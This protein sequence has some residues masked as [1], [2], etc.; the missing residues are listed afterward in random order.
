LSQNTENTILE[1]WQ[2]PQTIER[3]LGEDR[4][5]ALRRGSVDLDFHLRNFYRHKDV[6]VHFFD[7]FDE[8]IAVCQ[9]Y[10]INVIVVASGGRLVSEIELLRSIK[11]NVFLSI[12]PVVLYHPNP[13]QA[14]VIAAYENGVEDF[15]YGDWS[16]RLVEVRINRAIERNHRDLSINPSTYLPGP[17]MIDREIT[18]LIKA[19]SEFAV[20]YADLDNF[21]AFN[22]YYGYF[23][24]DK[25]IRLS[26]R[27][28][29]DIV[30]DLCRGGFVGHV[31]GDDY[32]F[33]IDPEQVDLI[34]SEIIRTFDALIPYQYE[35]EDRQRGHITTTNR[36]GQVE[37]F[38]LLTVS[39]AV[40]MNRGGEFQHVGEMSNMLADLKKAT[41]MIDGS[42]YLVERRRKY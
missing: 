12:I 40:L 3:E 23:R 39:I 5:F 35:Q 28:I 24:G 6:S 36:R 25:I 38:P 29:K 33:I 15:I 9:R 19:G 8:L 16:D 37:E 21:K 1:N 7:T 10:Q 20:C 41:K 13:S 30:F 22:D 42:A 27:V 11:C 14:D 17:A 4:H 2:G 34:C 32:I 26:A 18:R 31:A